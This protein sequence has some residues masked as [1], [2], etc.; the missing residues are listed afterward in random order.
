LRIAVLTQSYCSAPTGSTLA[1][2]YGYPAGFLADKSLVFA[3]TLSQ[4]FG[5]ACSKAE[6]ASCYSLV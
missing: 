6:N 4:K 1:K 2:S 5:S 3:A